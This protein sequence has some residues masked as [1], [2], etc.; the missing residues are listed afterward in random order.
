MQEEPFGIE[1]L[2][3]ACERADILSLPPRRFLEFAVGVSGCLEGLIRLL[4]CGLLCCM[5]TSLV[6]ESE[7]NSRE[8]YGVLRAGWVGEDEYDV[9]PHICA[10]ETNRQ[11]SLVYFPS[12]LRMSAAELLILVH[13]F[14]RRLR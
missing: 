2:E 1:R 13:W 14:I 9:L 6:P 8:M 3:N 7:A 5:P 10:P 12:G 4:G 11:L